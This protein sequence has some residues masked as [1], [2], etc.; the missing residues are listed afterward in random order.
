MVTLTQYTLPTYG[1]YEYPYYSAIIGWIYASIPILPIPVFMV[2]ELIKA[3][4]SLREV[5]YVIP[6]ISDLISEVR[7]VIPEISDLIREVRQVIPQISDLI[8]EVR[9]V[10]P[11][12]SDL[13]RG[14]TSHS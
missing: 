8:R 6:E 7:Q 14:K 12:I 3:K 5:R 11:Q 10:I 2:W 4:G 13:M 1:K 9:Q